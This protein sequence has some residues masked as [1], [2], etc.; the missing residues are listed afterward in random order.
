RPVTHRP[1]A[2]WHHDPRR[3]RAFPVHHD[4]RSGEL[5]PA[6]LLAGCKG[7]QAARDAWDGEGDPHKLGAGGWWRFWRMVEVVPSRSN[8]HQPP[9][10][11]TNLHNLRF[12]TPT[13]LPPAAGAGRPT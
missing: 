1:M 11:F 7:R 8:L 12:R 6:V 5:S 9:P 4:V 10:S 2:G 13:A 3:G